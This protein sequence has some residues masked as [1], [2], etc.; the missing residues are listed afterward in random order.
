MDSPRN[1]NIDFSDALF[2]L[3][4]NCILDGCS[5]AAGLDR[6]WEGSPLTVYCFTCKTRTALLDVVLPN[7]PDND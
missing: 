6:W 5:G 7:K 2:L 4:C 1:H 3:E